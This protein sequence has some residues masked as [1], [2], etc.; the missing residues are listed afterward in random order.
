MDEAQLLALFEREPNRAFGEKELI[1]E[2]RAGAGK[3]KA[4]RRALRTL[5]KAG[6]LERDAHRWRLSRSG[7][8]V[9]G[10]VDIADD[11][12]VFLALDGGGRRRQR[13]IPLAAED[14]SRV[15]PGDRIKAS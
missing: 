13:P 12:R 14:A 7:T 4:I 3:L 6:K 11:G 8:T 10:R 2:T 1:Q 9:E 5:T 15:K